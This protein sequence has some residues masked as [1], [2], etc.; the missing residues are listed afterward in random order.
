MLYSPLFGVLAC[1]VL[2]ACPCVACMSRNG[3]IITHTH[4]STQGHGSRRAVAANV[5]RGLGLPHAKRLRAQA[6]FCSADKTM[7]EITNGAD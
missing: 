2:H 4:D 5:S 3:R 6:K 1:H 7:L